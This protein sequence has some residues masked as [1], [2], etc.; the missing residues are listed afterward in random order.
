MEVALIS[1]ALIKYIMT[2][3]LTL[4]NFLIFAGF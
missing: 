3:I 4:F 1:G 2:I